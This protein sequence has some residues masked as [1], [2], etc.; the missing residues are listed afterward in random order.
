MPSAQTPA[1]HGSR[2]VSAPDPLIRGVDLFCGAGGLT[3]G[4]EE[5]GIGM[6]LGIDDDPACEH[7]YRANN[8]ARF[9]GAPIESIGGGDLAR[10][11][12]GGRFSLLAG[13]APCQPFSTY[14]QGR[15]ASSGARWSLLG[16]FARLIGETRPDLI[17]M[18]N[19]PRLERMG[20]FASFRQVL[21]RERYHVFH[22]LI[23]CADYGVPQA[24]RR[25]V[26]LA[27]RLGPLELPPPST[28]GSL[29]RTVRNAIGELPAIGAGEA[30]PGDPLHSACRL[31]PL[32]SRRIRASAPGGTWRDWDESLRAE[33]HRKESGRTYP[34]V[35]GR[36]RWDQPSPTITTQFYGYGNGRFG[37]PEQHRAI[38]LR[39]GAVLQGF[40]GDYQFGTPGSPVRRAAIGRM[41]GNAVPVALGRM[42]GRAIVR[43]VHGGS[44]RPQRPSR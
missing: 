25:L 7:P 21:E 1:K 35:Y 36:M 6:R 19:V 37:H 14:S 33:C 13:C 9:L 2:A 41:I 26:L 29:R 8:R 22:R 23:D 42:I 11:F 20:I 44:K 28:P 12:D 3:R 39:E 38:S 17:T 16:Q 15:R 10:E 4:L 24:R 40:P 27:S 31:S 34:G 18:E 43:H 30:C 5:A 32:N